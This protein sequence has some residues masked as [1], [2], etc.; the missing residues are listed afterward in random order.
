MVDHHPHT[1]SCELG[2][3]PGQQSPGT[4]RIVFG[5][6]Q[7]LLQ[8]GIHRFA[9]EPQPIELLLRLL[10]THGRLVELNRSEQL[11]RAILLQEV[12]EGRIIV[13]SISKQTLEVMC[14]RV[15][16]FHH[17]LVIVVTGSAERDRPITTPVRLTTLCSLGPKYFIALLLHTPYSAVPAKSLA[18]FVRLYPTHGTGAE[19]MAAVSSS[20]S[21]SSTTCKLMRTARITD[22]R[23]RFLRW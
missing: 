22:Q 4:I 12:L 19:S 15:K 7:L 14:K 3:N 11:Y 23:S 5:Q 10:G 2:S 16:Q 13:G 17:G 6:V 20:S 21:A 9:D 8:L 18:C 1:V